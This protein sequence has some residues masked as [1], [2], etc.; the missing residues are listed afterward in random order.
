MWTEKSPKKN[1]VAKPFA[2]YVPI[3]R[4]NMTN[5]YSITYDPYIDPKTGILRNKVGARTQAE[6]DKVESEIT[7]IVIAT[8]TRG[9]V[10]DSLVFDTALLMDVHHEIF[11]DI[12]PWAGKIRTQDISKET[13]LFAHAEYIQAGL[14]TIF[15][16]LNQEIDIG[17]RGRRIFV[18]R[19]AYYYGEL[20]AIHPFREGNGRTIRTFLR[21]FSIKH[22]YDINWERLDAER[23]ITACQEALHG[24]LDAMAALLDI[25][26]IIID[27]QKAG[28]RV[29]EVDR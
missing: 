15:Q 4:V 10:V 8:L 17:T 18:E 13:A 22:G 29:Y 5:R 7:Y 27:D 1:C 11:R 24:R 25:L 9:S 20:N 21:L 23:N 14:E 19:L 16:Q 2:S 12:Y 28:K 26:V 6:L 3:M